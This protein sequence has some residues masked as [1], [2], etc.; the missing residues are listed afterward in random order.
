MSLA[1]EKDFKGLR[2]SCAQSIVFTFRLRL[3]SITT[4]VI[5]FSGKKSKTW[6]CCLIESLVLSGIAAEFHEIIVKML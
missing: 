5:T 4:K 1:K 6:N 3:L 2:N